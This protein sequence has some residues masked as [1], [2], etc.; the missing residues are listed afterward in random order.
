MSMDH[1]WGLKLTLFLEEADSGMA[2]PVNKSLGMELPFEFMGFPTSFTPPDGEGTASMQSATS[3]PINHAVQVMTT[4]EYFRRWLGWKIDRPLT[5]VEWLSISSQT[6][7]EVTS[8]AVYCDGT[9][10]L[11]RLRQQLAWYPHDVWLYLLACCWQRI[12]QEELLMPRAGYVGDELGSAL[13]GSQLVRDSMTLCFLMEKQYPPYPNWFGTAYQ[14]LASASAL[15][16]VLWKV[17]TAVSWQDRQAALCEAFELLAH[18]HNAL[19]I[20]KALS[21]KV[22]PYYERPF[23]VIGGG[24]FAE[25][26]LAEIADPEVQAVARLGLVGSLDLISDNTDLRS[27]LNWRRRLRSLLDPASEQE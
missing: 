1:D 20:T 19:G 10:Q 3:R 23:L 11:G 18:K 15:A 27:G 17:Q 6:L 21:E 9:R 4:G 16:P 24:R 25:A 5:V 14:R 26:L 13:I 22:E 8:G 12:G 2:E 7:R